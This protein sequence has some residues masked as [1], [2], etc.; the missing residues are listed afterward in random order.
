INEAK[1]L[2]LTAAQAQ[3]LADQYFGIKDSGDIKKQIELI[4]A[5]PVKG[6]LDDILG[7]L[8]TIASLQI[9]PTISVQV[10]QTS[11]GDACRILNGFATRKQ[12]PIG[13]LVPVGT[14]PDGTPGSATGGYLSGP[15][16]GT[17]DSL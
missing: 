4:G 7:V 16:T 11:V 15:G 13:P 12:V 10:D 6:V 17:S 14:Q 2:G 9:R 1:Q 3:A 5:G 8:K